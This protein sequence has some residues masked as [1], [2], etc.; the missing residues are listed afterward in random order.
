MNEEWIKSVLS[1]DEDSSDEE[2][3]AYFM[4]EGGLTKEEAVAWVTKRSFYLN[5]IVRDDGMVFDPESRTF[6]NPL[7]KTK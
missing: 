5:N 2:L 1:N 7:K 6:Y 4:Q 3:V